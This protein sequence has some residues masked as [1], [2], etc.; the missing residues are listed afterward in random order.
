MGW[1]VVTDSSILETTAEVSVAF[2]GF[3]SIF[4]VLASRDGRFPLRD[5]FSIRVIVVSGVSPVFY[6]ILPLLLHS[7]GVSEPAVWMASSGLMAVIFASIF[8]GVMLPRWR[9]VN[10]DEQ[11]STMDFLNLSSR[12]LGAVS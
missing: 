5:A 3:I 8:A 1:R 6:A 10:E 12:G 9:A 7:L 2:A 4:L 11:V